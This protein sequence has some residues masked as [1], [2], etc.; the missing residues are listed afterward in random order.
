MHQLPPQKDNWHYALLQ[1][2]SVLQW[3]DTQCVEALETDSKG[4]Q[5][6]GSE[7]VWNTFFFKLK[8]IV[9][10][11]KSNKDHQSHVDSSFRDMLWH[12]LCD[13]L[14]ITAQLLCATM[15]LTVDSQFQHFTKI[16]WL[17]KVVKKA[18][19]VIWGDGWMWER[20]F[21]TEW[22]ST[23]IQHLPKSSF[24]WLIKVIWM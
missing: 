24:C 23:R 2:I 12:Q 4:C 15:A 10:Q 7:K 9:V 6:V 5:W 20:T 3:R 22:T 21:S 11:K 19:R 14:I 13:R 16:K 17:E 1:Q 8:Q 18:W